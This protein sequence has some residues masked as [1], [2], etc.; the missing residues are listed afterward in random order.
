MRTTRYLFAQLAGCQNL[1]Y[2]SPTFLLIL[3]TLIVGCAL[4]FSSNLTPEEQVAVVTTDKGIVV[5][6]FYPD[7]APIAVENFIKLINQKFYDGLTF[8]RRVDEFVVQG[9][10][11]NGDGTG[12]PGWNITDEYTNPNQ[13]PHL[14]GT[15]AMARTQAPNS[16]GSQFYICFKPQPYLDG[17][18]TTFGGVIQ[19]MDV[20]D[21]LQVGDVMTKIRLEAKSKYVKATPE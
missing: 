18:Y 9:G 10:C 4:P 11:P 16:S 5:I 7:A 13:R 19:G 14:R 2:K 20:V 3:L 15:V 17:N 21:R 6:E 12:G 1:L 8:H